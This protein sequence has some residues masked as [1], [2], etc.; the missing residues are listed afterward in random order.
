MQTAADKIILH[1]SP[2]S[3][4]NDPLVRAFV[5]LSPVLWYVSNIQDYVELV[6]F[7]ETPQ[8]RP[9][10]SLHSLHLRTTQRSNSHMGSTRH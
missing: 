5:V 1:P 10:L 7:Q 3:D 2:S 4:P 9:R 6:A 8:L